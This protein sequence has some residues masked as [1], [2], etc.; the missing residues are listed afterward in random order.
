MQMLADLA[1]SGSENKVFRPFYAFLE[2][3]RVGRDNFSCYA[4]RSDKGHITFCRGYTEYRLSSGLIE[5]A[6][7]REIQA[8]IG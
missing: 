5:L 1:D 2:S 3:S 7:F 8:Q 4:L 6:N